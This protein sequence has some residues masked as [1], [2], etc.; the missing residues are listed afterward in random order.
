MGLPWGHYV[1]LIPSSFEGSTRA[2]SKCHLPEVVHHGRPGEP[3]IDPRGWD[4]GGL[5][6]ATCMNPN[7]ER[8]GLHLGHQLRNIFTV[9]S[10]KSVMIT[11]KLNKENAIGQLVSPS[12]QD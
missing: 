6:S 2:Q 1:Q 10:T 12:Q 9:S 11:V 5:P 7:H 8:L 4:P 3:S